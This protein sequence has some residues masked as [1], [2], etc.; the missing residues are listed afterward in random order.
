MFLVPF[1]ASKVLRKALEVMAGALEG[2]KDEAG[3][4]QLV[5][6]ENALLAWDIEDGATFLADLILER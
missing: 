2:V 3:I 6:A 4:K 5:S 1:P